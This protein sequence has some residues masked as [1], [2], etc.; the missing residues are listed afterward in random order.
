MHLILLGAPGSGK[1]TIAGELK[2]HY[3]LAHISTGDIFRHHIKEKTALG[4]EARRYIDQGL[5]VPDTLTITM[6]EE[7]LSNPDCSKGFILDGFPR[8]IAQAEALEEL[9][10]TLGIQIDAV[11]CLQVSDELIKNRVSGRRVCLTC[12]AS[13]NLPNKPPKQDGICDICGSEII[14]REDDRPQTV[15]QRLST[16]HEKTQPLIDFYLEREKLLFINNENG[17]KDAIVD[18][19]KALKKMNIS[20][21]NGCNES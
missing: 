11:I 5:L 20:V 17:Y 12:G 14:Q 13:Y 21:G 3:Q 7:R 4:I 8:T 16:Y 2:L 1:G 6:V 19:E 15:L 9:V 10:K 18:I